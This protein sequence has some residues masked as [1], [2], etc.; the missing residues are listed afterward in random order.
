MLKVRRVEESD[1]ELLDA[2]ARS[3]PF[4]LAAGLTGQHWA[5][6]DT[7]FYE[8]ELGPVVALKTT[9]VVRVDVQFLTQEKARNARALVAGFYSYVGILQK[10]GV[11]ELVFNTESPDVAEFFQKRFHFRALNSTST[12]SLWIGD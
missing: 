9:N 4:H 2:A 7:L 12:Y 8:D 3:D 5:G 11:K 10:R 1:R 6:K